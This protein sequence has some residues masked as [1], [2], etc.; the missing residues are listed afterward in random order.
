MTEKLKV[1]NNMVKWGKRAAVVS[2]LIPLIWEMKVE[3]DSAEEAV[4]IIAQGVGWDGKRYE[5][6]L[7]KNTK[8]RAMAGGR[9]MGRGKPQLDQEETDL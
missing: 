2:N 5:F 1:N 9:S 8:V 6:E 4:K 7:W 3:M